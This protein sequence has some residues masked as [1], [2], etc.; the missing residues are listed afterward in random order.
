MRKRDPEDERQVILG[1]TNEGQSM[2]AEAKAVCLELA[3]GL[4][5]A[6]DRR[7]IGQFDQLKGRTPKPRR[8]KAG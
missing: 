6:T 8:R 2:K 1:V 5:V 3:T 7:A 4:A